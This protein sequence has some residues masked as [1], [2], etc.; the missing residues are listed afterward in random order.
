MSAALTS[1][2]GT[3]RCHDSRNGGRRTWNARART[4]VTRI[5]AVH[6][7]TR[8]RILQR[9]FIGSA[10]NGKGS[11]VS[12][13]FLVRG[14]SAEWQSSRRR[15]E[16]DPADPVAGALGEPD[17]PVRPRGDPEGSACR[18]GNIHLHDPSRQGDAPDTVRRQLGEPYPAVGACGDSARIASGGRNRELGD[19]P[20]RRDAS[21]AVSLE[22]R[23]PDVAV[24]AGR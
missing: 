22:L 16:Q 15:V 21:D 12:S 13:A 17:V 8:R 20:V 19:S 23:E 4:I 7:T 3:N 2:G 9:C 6:S 1:D 5:S 14:K 11:Y 10:I 24:R 18:A